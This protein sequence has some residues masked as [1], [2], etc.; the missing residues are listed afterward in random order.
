MGEKESLYF[1]DADLIHTPEELNTTLSSI[2]NQK[3]C[4]ARK[5]VFE[6]FD[7]ATILNKLEDIDVIHCG[8]QF[9]GL[10]AF[11]ELQVLTFN[12]NFLIP[13][14]SKEAYTWRG[15]SDFLCLD[16]NLFRKM[17]GFVQ[18]LSLNASIMEFCYRTMMAGGN[19]KNVPLGVEKKNAV[20]TVS[21]QDSL[22][23][24]LHH[25]GKKAQLFLRFFYLVAYLSLPRSKKLKPPPSINY[26]VH[27]LFKVKKE[28]KVRSI[29]KYT[30][31]IPTIDRYDYIDKSIQSL[32]NNPFPPDEIIVV[33]QTPLRKRNTSIYEPYLKAGVVRLFFLDTPGQCTSRNLAISEAKNEWL[34]FFEDDTEAWP[35]MMK[36]H[37]ELLEYS[38]ADVSTG[39]SLA[40]WKD[41]KYISE[42]MKRYHI[43]DVLAT[44]NCLM[45]REV[46]L[47]VGGLH[48]AFNRGSGADDDFGKRLFL[49]GKQIVFNF[50]AIQTH[51]K[52]PQGG[53][54]VHGAWWRNSSNIFQ[55]FPPPTQMY[56]IQK[57]YPAKFW[58]FQNLLFYIQSGKGQNWF[59][60][61]L[62]ILFSPVKIIRSFLAAKILKQN[63]EIS[64]FES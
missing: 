25:V 23:F 28:K 21:K 61:L 51:H 37:I 17:N 35:E 36:E 53:M 29:D 49:S 10:T 8:L 15:T 5:E 18:G 55:A 9:E 31:I 46:A 39:V 41:E 13:D 26:S 30:A 7:T 6:K 34:L 42:K 45:H 40:P 33:D 4:L 1:I 62:S 11:R 56:M 44:G 50:K 2:S 60:F 59:R 64:Q 16:S 48:L 24:S 58:L 12:W 3:I 20:L 38:F 22:Y 54:R 47:S 63:D 52:A 57:Y 27:Y 19:V 14:S 43:A 32:L